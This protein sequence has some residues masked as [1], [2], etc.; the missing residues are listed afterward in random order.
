M[1]L[2]K[3]IYEQFEAVVGP[4]YI[5]DDPAVLDT[6]VTPM[7]QSQHHMGPAYNTFTPRGQA[8][9]LP[10]KTE[11]V[12][13]IVRLC[14]KYKIKYKAA[15]TFWTSRANISDDY[16]ITLD[17]RRMDRI[18][19]INR[20]DQYAVIEPYVIGSTLQAE[21]MKVGL[22]TTIIGAGS[23]CSPL[24]SACANGG[25]SPFALYGGLLRENLLAFEWVM[26]TGEILRS[27][28]QGQGLGW[29]CDDG[30]GPGMRG[31]IMA[32]QGSMGALG[33]FTKCAIKLFPWPGPPDFPTEGITP[34]Y[35]SVLPPNIQ[36][37]TV[38]WSSWEG[39]ANGLYRIWDSGISGYYSHRQYTMFGRD[40]KAAMIKILTDPNGTLNDLESLLKD[41]DLNRQNEEMK[42]DFQ[43]VLAGMT[44]RDIAWQEKVLDKILAETGGC[45]ASLLEQPEIRDWS[46]LFLLRLGH[47]NLNFVFAGGYEGAFGIGGV[48]D[49]SCPKVEMAAEFKKKWEQSHTCFV[50]AG[51]DCMMG[52]MGGIGGGGTTAWENFTHFDSH[53]KE[54]VEV[55]HEYFELSS[56]YGRKTGLGAM[57]RMY[58]I[59]RHDNGYGLSKEEQEAKLAGS[60]QPLPYEYQWMIREFLDPN[61]L[62]DAY[63]VTMEPKHVHK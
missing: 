6:Y 25:P 10:A 50:A 33:V 59:S 27:G 52:G 31:L 2:A 8:V 53:D 17:M 11:E 41:P 1:A 54:S 20:K 48:P 42:R 15:S 21:A 5:T 62:G 18:L 14:N 3:E 16:A 39:Y 24:A 26:P 22:N 61:H 30:P 44:N 37:H 19:E 35:R 63:Y 28:S 40:L 12:Q 58:A 9:L 55:T 43:I 56:E 29:F 46:L 32:G 45:K 34:A 51:G 38:C 57:E 49:F 23:S 36:G 60:P 4:D 13:A 47:K 7:A